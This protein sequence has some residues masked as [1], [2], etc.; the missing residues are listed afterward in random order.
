[1]CGFKLNDTCR[2]TLFMV[3][4]VLFFIN[5]VAAT[6]ADD[7]ALLQDPTPLTDQYIQNRPAQALYHIEVRANVT[8][9][10]VDLHWQAGQAHAALGDLQAAVAHWQQAD[11]QNVDVLRRL[12]NAYIT[13]GDWG[14][15]VDTLEALLQVDPAHVWANYQLGV[16][17]A[18]TDS[19]RALDYLRAVPVGSPY[20]IIV[21]RAAT[22]IV[23]DDNV[24][25]AMRVGLLLLNEGVPD[26]AEIAFRQA[27]ALAYPY[28]E[29][30]A[31]LAIAREE[32]GK[33]GQRSMQAALMLDPNMAVVQ[34]LH[35]I[36]LRSRDELEASRDAL[37]GAV[38][39]D[40]ENAA[41]H[42]ELGEAHRLLGDYNRAEATL[43]RAVEVSGEASLYRELL[44]RFYAQEGFNLSA[45]SLAA[46][47][48]TADA[49]PLD[50]SLMAGF[51][52]ALHTMGDTQAAL[53]EVQT[54]LAL[55]GSHPEALY[56]QARILADVGETEAA[57]PILERV[58][59]LE[60]PFT[61]LAQTLLAEINTN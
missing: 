30:L 7:A 53:T 57:I 50:P 56:T 40:V 12:S 10:T 15:A 26:A 43:Q 21:G 59:A 17:L 46:A 42:A 33:D 4:S 18:A 23:P 6:W 49:L 44:A 27:A 24:L 14:L 3:L 22:A 41:Y 52:W 9:W 25:N 1:M 55:D 34:Y 47:R 39:L 20:E 51:A 13:L 2:A 28:P 37:V 16:L 54:A 19:A 45:D 11:L 60:S 58:I 32:Q 36:Y 48:I 31:Y 5:G 8:G 61:A 35:G 29:A 38:A